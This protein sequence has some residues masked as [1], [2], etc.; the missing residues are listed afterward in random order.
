MQTPNN[1]HNE[2][3]NVLESGRV[4]SG[5]IAEDNRKNSILVLETIINH[6]PGFDNTI[7]HHTAK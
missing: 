6:L 4:G 5:S 1:S 2:N 3:S 7:L